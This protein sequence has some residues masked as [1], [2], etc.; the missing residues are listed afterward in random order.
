MRLSMFREKLAEKIKEVETTLQS[1]SSLPSQW[2]QVH[3]YCIA[4][5]LRRIIERHDRAYRTTNL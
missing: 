1:S 5:L 2:L 3:I 4:A